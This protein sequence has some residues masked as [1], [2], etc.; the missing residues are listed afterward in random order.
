MLNNNSIHSLI[1]VANINSGLLDKN[2]VSSPD[3]FKK[4][5]DKIKG[6]PILIPADENIFEFRDNDIFEIQKNQILSTIYEHQNDT[7]VGFKHSFYSFKFLSK[8]KIK[9]I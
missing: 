7:Y 2:F 1:S 6:I 5:N 8:F 4:F 9:K 3:E